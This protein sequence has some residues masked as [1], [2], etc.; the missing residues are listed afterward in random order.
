MTSYNSNE[1][2]R[3]DE[4]TG[5]V[6]PN[7]VVAGS[8]GLHQP[9]GLVIDANGDL[10]VSSSATNRIL[11]YDGTDGSFKD[12]FTDQGSMDDPNGIT[13]GPNGNVFVSSTDTDEVKQ[14]DV[15]DGSPIAIPPLQNGNF[16]VSPAITRPGRL[17]FGP[18][19]D[20]Y[21]LSVQS[22][23]GS[24]HRFDGTT[25][26]DLGIFAAH[27]DLINPTGLTF[28]P[29]GD[30]YV[31]DEVSGNIKLFDGTTGFYNGVFA[32]GIDGPVD[33]LGRPRGIAFGPD[34]HLYVADWEDDTI[35]RFSGTNGE[36]IDVFASGG[37]LNGAL[38]LV[39]TSQQA[40][41]EPS[42]YALAA[43]G[44]VALGLYGWR[45]RRSRQRA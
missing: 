16:V 7:S 23:T 36:F 2:I 10:L 14:F 17:K 3:Y 45:R 43:F 32:D 22:G 24:V 1:V 41:P 8:G 6:L 35:R 11:R 9:I 5:A 13:I 27:Q 28:G 38:D 40:V 21:V 12:I 44:L 42:T 29:N 39:F 26:A 33:E 18:D 37:G 15:L 31:S 4:T 25:G 19:G 30:L 34:G 20:L